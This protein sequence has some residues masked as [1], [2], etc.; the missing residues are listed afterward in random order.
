ML[1]F[2]SVIAVRVGL[3]T[4]S[5][6]MFWLAVVELPLPSVKVQVTTVTPWAVIGKLTFGVPVIVPAQAS[7]VVGAVGVPE[8]SPILMAVRVGVT[9]G[10]TS[11]S[12]MV[13]VVVCVFPLPSLAVIV[14]SCVVLC[15]LMIVPGAGSCVLMMLPTVVQLS[16]AVVKAV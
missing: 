14:M 9:G 15:P 7:V 1:S 11:F 5:S 4:S 3:V 12:V 13:K 10:V 8:H 2:L 6:V 16:A